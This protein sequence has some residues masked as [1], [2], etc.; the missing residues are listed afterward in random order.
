MCFILHLFKPA[1]VA[2]FPDEKEICG[3]FNSFFSPQISF[4][5]G[6]RAA[7]LEPLGF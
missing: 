4:S 5:L 7:K 1:L 2:H 6:G 3:L